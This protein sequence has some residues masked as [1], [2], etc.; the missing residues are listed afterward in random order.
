MLTKVSYTNTCVILRSLELN[1]M[2]NAIFNF[3]SQVGE[4]PFSYKGLKKIKILKSTYQISL[5][6]S[7]HIAC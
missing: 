4:L 6:R 1:S 2:T 3:Q 5:G 7:L